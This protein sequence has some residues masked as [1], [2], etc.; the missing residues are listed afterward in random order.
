MLRHPEC[1]GPWAFVRLVNATRLATIERRHVEL[2]FRMRAFFIAAGFEQKSFA[3]HIGRASLFFVGLWLAS[4]IAGVPEISLRRELA[5]ASG[6]NLQ[7]RD[8][9]DSI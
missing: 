7:S 2:G 4:P 8:S 9:E 5:S 3:L 1:P 6:F